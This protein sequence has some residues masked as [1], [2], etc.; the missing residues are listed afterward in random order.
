[1]AQKHLFLAVPLLPALLA[2]S[3]PG[4]ASDAETSPETESGPA[5]TSAIH[6]DM[7]HKAATDAALLAVASVRA[8]NKLDLDIRLLGPTSVMIASDR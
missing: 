1:M 7:A 6:R 4:N 8:D 2:L 5:D 3:V